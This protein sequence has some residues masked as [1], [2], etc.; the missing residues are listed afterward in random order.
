M[1]PRYLL[2]VDI[3]SSSVRVIAFDDRLAEIATASAKRLSGPRVDAD[4]CWAD[5]SRLLF[6][7]MAVLPRGADIRAVAVSALL[8]WVAVDAA[9]RPVAEAFTWMDQRPEETAELAA[10]MDS[11]QLYAKTGRRLSGEFG[12][13]KLRHLKREHPALYE[14]TAALLSLKDYINL[15]LTGLMSTDVTTACYTLL[16]N[17]GRRDWDDDILAAL[18]LDRAR[19]PRLLRGSEPAGV[20]TPEVERLCGLPAGTPVAASGPDGS[21]G[22]L[23]AGGHAVGAAVDLMGTTDV[24]F[25]VCDERP[26]D[27]GRTLVVNPHLIDGLWL[28]GGPMGLSGGALDWVVRTLMDRHV[29]FE[30]VDGQAAEIE[31]GCGGLMMIPGFTGER[32][33]FWEPRMAGTM[34][35][36]RLEHQAAHFA[37]AIMEANSFAV[38]RL[39]ARCGEAGVPIRELVAIGGGI[40]HQSWLTV[41]ADV[42]GLPLLV[43]TRIEA[44]S[45]GCA[46]LAL[47]ATGCHPGEL[48]VLMAR[49]HRRV[50]PDP[51]RSALYEPLYHRYLRLIET[52][53]EFYN[54]G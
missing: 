49:R 26:D 33:P 27:P 8:G 9:G 25:A 5:V 47:L 13:L 4:A 52:A 43:A 17:I 41:K 36:L 51:G 53:A 24:L 39:C 30:E 28:A 45:L 38:R 48:S 46:A 42:T 35:G 12:G 16:F 29:S 2:T 50:L 32:A 1:A 15:R 23:G 14:R 31:P 20:T 7:V 37:R 10:A 18:S 19:L 3:G 22:I 11:R 54:Q 44:T 40:R 21:V 34:I 6:E